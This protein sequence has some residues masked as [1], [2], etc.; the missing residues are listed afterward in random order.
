VEAKVWNH[1]MKKSHGCLLINSGYAY[2][3]DAVSD[4]NM[5]F[6][7]EMIARAMAGT[8][9]YYDRVPCTGMLQE[10]TV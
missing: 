3:R 4:K 6:E 1:G 5:P 10:K 8:G 2:D 7:I 9:A